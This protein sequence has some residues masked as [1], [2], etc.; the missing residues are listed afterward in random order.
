MCNLATSPAPNVRRCKLRV[1]ELLLGK[2][3]T[4][5]DIVLTETMLH[6][7]ETSPRVL[8]CL[9]VRIHVVRQSFKLGLPME[10]LEF[11]SQM[12]SSYAAARAPIISSSVL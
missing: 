5:N 10:V 4:L 8:Y 7:L 11:G 2:Q 6:P 12:K 1:N 9:F 3:Q